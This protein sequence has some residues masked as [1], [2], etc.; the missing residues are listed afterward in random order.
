MEC[1]RLGDLI[2]KYDLT[3]R[4]ATVSHANSHAAEIKSPQLIANQLVAGFNRDPGGIRTPNQQNRNLPFYPI[5][6]RS[7]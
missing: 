2:E 3:F 7:Q 5:E 6:L 1:T 4:L